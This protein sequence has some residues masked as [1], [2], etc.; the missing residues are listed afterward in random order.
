MQE[1]IIRLN[2]VDLWSKWGFKDGDILRDLNLKNDEHDMIYYLVNK[3]LLTLIKDPIKTMFWF[4]SH[5]PCRI[6]EE[7]DEKYSGLQYDVDGIYVD[8]PIEIIMQE[9]VNLRLDKVRDV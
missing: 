1:K 2:A 9:D 3:Y 5:N 4:S 7:D 8:I 6:T